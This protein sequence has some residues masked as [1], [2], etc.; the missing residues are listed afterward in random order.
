MIRNS[1]PNRSLSLLFT[2]KRPLIIAS[3]FALCALLSAFLQGCSNEEPKPVAQNPSP[4]VDNTR[5]HSRVEEKVYGAIN[6][7]LPDVLPGSVWISL[8]EGSHEAPKLDLLIHFHGIH[9]LVGYA[10][11]KYPRAIIATSVN[12]GSGSSRYNNAFDHLNAFSQF[13]SS[14]VDA[15][16]ERLGRKVEIDALILS[17]FSAGYGAIR[18]ILHEPENYEYVDAVLLLDGI[19]AGYIPDGGE[20]DSL[21]VNEFVSLAK[22]AASNDSSKRFLITHSSIFPG[23][24]ASTTEVTDY[25]LDALGL[26]RTPVMSWGPL[27]MQQ[28]SFAGHNRFAIMGF[29]GN[30][31]VDHMDHLNALYY[32]LERLE[33]L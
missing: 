14:I 24:Y 26:K 27:G 10:A 21:D 18:R 4:M 29:A 1:V 6:F 17:G 25:M 16:E 15:V 31:A 19:H 33:E 30:T 2:D 20:I 8:P 13:Y 9:Y 22:D 5:E 7:D 32:F 3:R 12:L 11:T 23:T 28:L